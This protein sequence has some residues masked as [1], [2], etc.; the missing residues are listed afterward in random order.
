M[1]LAPDRH[2]ASVR[3][4][5]VSDD[6]EPEPGS[7]GLAGARLVHPVET[8]KGSRQGLRHD[9]NTCVLYAHR[10]TVP[11]SIGEDVDRAA[12]ACILYGVI[13]QIHENLLDLV[14]ICIRDKTRC[15][16]RG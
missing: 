13:D 16:L 9:A 11:L 5:D 6:G 8:L 10:D 1:I 14:P 3:F 7:A 15:D 12:C 4:Y 2:G